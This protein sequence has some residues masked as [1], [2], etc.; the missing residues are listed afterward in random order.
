MKMTGG[1]AIVG[2]MIA[3]GTEI[4]FGLPGVQ[5]DWLYNALYDAGDA[6][7]V[8]HTRHE[9]GAGYM[10]LG[11]AMSTG[12]PGVYAVVPGVGLL[13]SSSALATAYSVNAP[14]FCF[15]GQIPSASIGRGHGQLHEVPDQLGILER[16]TKWAT[17]IKSPA[18]A[19]A[20]VTEAF[21]K[22]QTGRP[23]PVAVECPLDVLAA[24]AQI[25]S[26]DLPLDIRHPAV[27]EEVLEEAA[28]LLGQAKNPLIFVGS[29]AIGAS[30]GICELAEQLQAP[31]VANNSGHG[32]LSSR[33]YLSLRSPDA[34]TLWAT[35][36][37]VLAVGSRLQRP[38]MTWGM[39][40]DLKIIRIDIDPEEHY[41]IAEPA[42]GLIARSEDAIP[43]LVKQVGKYNQVRPSRQDDLNDLRAETDSRL[44]ALEPQ[45]SYLKA[46]RDVLPDD[47]ILVRDVTQIGYVSGVG[48]PTYHPR[49]MLGTGYQGTLGWG[50][51]TSLGA[52]VANP[53][54]EVLAVCGDGGFMFT[55]Q[56]LAT[57]VQHKIATVTL[58][59]NDGAYGNVKRMQKENYGN[60]LI[61]SDLQ[62]PDF[63]KLAESFGALG[64]RATTPDELR[65][66][67]EQ[68]FA[69]GQ[70]TLIEIP[71]G[72]VPSPWGAIMMPRSRG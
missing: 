24:T 57:A 12:K 27:D 55:V 49:T 13:N 15:T 6:I 2:A 71:I 36:D 63:V 31:V 22:L 21:R 50:F 16:L 44:A 64:L 7:K 3:Q 54:K 35:A 70:P 62:N 30:E 33:H 53:G 26:T 47:G 59:F 51:A 68:G 17:R 28:K 8:I 66:A 72:E 25:E 42:V 61:G 45:L 65:P 20:L 18:E 43:L 23:R 5:N 38:M 4:L 69:S 29:G 19:P 10:A 58:V 60:R 48:F 39:D 67:L 34:H 32:I 41:R 37:V 56:E 1:E 52:K 14:V 11:Y 40:D 9:Q 46:I